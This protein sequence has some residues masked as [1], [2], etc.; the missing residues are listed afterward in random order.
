MNKLLILKYLP[1]LGAIFLLFACSPDN[2]DITSSPNGS[3]WTGGVDGGVFI[4]IEDDE[5]T[6]DNIYQGIVY[7]EYD[8]SVWYK[9]K[10]KYSRNSTFDY[11]NK[12]NYDGWDG[13]K[14]FL[15]D[16]SYLTATNPPD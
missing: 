8:K 5:N 16:G 1:L 7:Y 4:R 3:W 11:K 13:E 9:G 2:S 12:L 10:F 15:K 6:N 14:L